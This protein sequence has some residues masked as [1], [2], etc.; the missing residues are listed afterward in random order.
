MLAALQ[1]VFVGCHGLLVVKNTLMHTSVWGAEINGSVRC[2]YLQQPLNKLCSGPWFVRGLTLQNQTSDETVPFSERILGLL[3]C[4]VCVSVESK[5]GGLGLFSRFIAQAY[6]QYNTLRSVISC[7]HV[8]MFCS[9][10]TRL[11]V[12]SVQDEFTAHN[13]SATRLLHLAQAQNV[14]TTVQ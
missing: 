12:M 6:F 9:T 10:G 11:V 7:F 1:W 14:H 2:L 4:C 5:Y 8:F 13:T 3:L